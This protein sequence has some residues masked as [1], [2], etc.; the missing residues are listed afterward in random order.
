MA[1]GTVTPSVPSM[2]LTTSSDGYPT[3][4]WAKVSGATQ[5]EIYRGYTDNFSI[6]RRTSA[7]TYTDTTA[8]AGERYSYK[9]RSVNGD[10]Y[11]DFCAR[12]AITCTAA[13]KMS[14]MTNGGEIS[15]YTV[16]E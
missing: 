6:I 2:S 4:S 13:A 7:L 16:S 8:A 10:M 3:I 5:Y 9:V 11:S 15:G 12:Q 14:I 1:G